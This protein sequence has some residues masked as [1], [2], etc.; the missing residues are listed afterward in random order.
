[1]RGF[2]R[3]FLEVDD[4]LFESVELNNWQSYRGDKNKF[5]FSG[6]DSTRNSAIIIGRNGKGKSAF[7]E[8]LRFLLYGGETIVVRESTTK[9]KRV[10][11]RVA[12]NK[13]RKSVV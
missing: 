9:P 1:M 7:F 10:K 5:E 13:D 4:L 2:S 6:P 12:E 11:P 3:K 8:S